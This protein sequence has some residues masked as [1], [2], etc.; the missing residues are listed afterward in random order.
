[1][2]KVT[3]ATSSLG[4]HINGLTLVMALSMQIVPVLDSPTGV[5]RINNFMFPLHPSVLF[6]CNFFPSFVLYLLSFPVLLL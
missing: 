3:E 5:I 2:V 1:M 4:L 6:C